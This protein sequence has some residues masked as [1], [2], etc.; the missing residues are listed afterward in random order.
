MSSR[1]HHVA[2]DSQNIGNTLGDR[3]CV[4]QSKYFRQYES[5][6]SMK[7]LLGNSNLGWN[8]QEKEG[9]FKGQKV[10]DFDNAHNTSAKAPQ[11]A[12]QSRSPAATTSYRDRNPDGDSDLFWRDT[13]AM[14]EK[15]RLRVFPDSCAGIG[16]SCSQKQHGGDSIGQ[17]SMSVKNFMPGSRGVAESQPGPGGDQASSMTMSRRLDEMRNGRQSSKR[18]LGGASVSDIIGGISGANS[19]LR[20]VSHRR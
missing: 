15:P 7:G 1:G 9:V 4:R 13:A 2:F 14:P 10:Y 6:N 12:Y 16:G 3:S 5:G 17:P 8:T 20:V 11:Q 19:E 18:I